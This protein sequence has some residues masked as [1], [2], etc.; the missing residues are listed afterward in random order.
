MTK[1][2]SP[3]LP[4]VLA[5]LS[6]APGCNL[7]D[8]YCVGDCP[9]AQTDGDATASVTATEATFDPSATTGEATTTAPLDDA[10]SDCADLEDTIVAVA[11][12]E[13]GSAAPGELCY[14]F[15]GGSFEYPDGVVSIAALQLDAAGDDILLVHEDGIVMRSLYA[16]GPGLSPSDSD[17]ATSFGPGTLQLSGVGDF[18]EDGVLDVAARLTADGGDT[19]QVLR[20]DGAGGLASAST[21][22]TAP[23]LSAP[24][25]ADYDADGHLD[26]VVADQQTGDVNVL[27]GD[28][29]G[30]FVADLEFSY[31]GA[32]G[33]HVLVAF[34]DDKIRD[35]FA[36]A[37]PNGDLTLYHHMI[38]SEGFE[39]VKIGTKIHDLAAADMNGDG[40][41]DVVALVDGPSGHSEIAVVL[42]VP[43]NPDGVM[44]FVTSYYP[45]HCGAT[46]LAVGDVDADGLLDVVTI[47]SDSPI[48]LATILRGDGLGLFSGVMSVQVG[49][50]VD[51]LQL[52]DLNSDGGIELITMSREAG[53]Y[54]VILSSP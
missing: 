2:R 12:C 36:F 23:A 20:L 16:A 15:G 22:M 42:Q 5:L 47:S 37:A 40:H 35:D 51:D 3:R 8:K 4:L 6:A 7:L 17:W 54:G 14:L 18:D 28:G 33:R 49:G 48:S 52:A 11:G 25:V 44:G 41:E 1:I 46:V 27:H 39:V 26:L 31:T 9:E 10:P 43:V 32:K 38:G 13:D 53:S 50:P 19:I 30:G 21:L 29:V 24:K 34:G 45:V